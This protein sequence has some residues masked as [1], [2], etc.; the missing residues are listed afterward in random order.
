MLKEGLDAPKPLSATRR[1]TPRRRH[2][3]RGQE[4]RGG[5]QLSL[6]E[7][8]ADGADERH[9]ALYAGQMR[10]LV[11]DAERRGGARRG[12]RSLRPAGRQ[13]RRLQVLSAAASAG[14]AAPT[15]SSQAVLIAKQMPGT[16]VKLLWTREEDMTHVSVPPDH[17]MQMRGGLD[18][19]GKLVGW[20]MRI[21]G[22]S[23]LAVAVA[24]EFEGRHGPG[25]PSR[26]STRAGRRA[27]SVIRSRTC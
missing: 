18:A 15:M 9:G 6:P 24:A 2:R 7:P 19:A 13:M 16:P 22:Q 20:Q 12:R 8:R 14:A 21:S 1:A 5:L 23:I 25:Q 4:G 26:G 17:A 27:H 3:R 11:P 10:G